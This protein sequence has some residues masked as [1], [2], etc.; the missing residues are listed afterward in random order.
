MGYENPIRLLEKLRMKKL[1]VN[2]RVKRLPPPNATTLEPTD[3]ARGIRDNIDEHNC[4][5]TVKSVRQE[6]TSNAST[7]KEE[8]MMIQVLWDNGTLSF[9]GPERLEAVS[10]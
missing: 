7:I 9:L 3:G 6:T 4:I 8:L 5:G 1:K 10:G 2:D